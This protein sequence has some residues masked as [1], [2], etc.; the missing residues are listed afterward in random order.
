MAA[1]GSTFGASM[2]PAP[3]PTPFS[4]G[5]PSPFASPP[6]PSAPAG[7]NPPVTIGGRNPRDILLQFYQQHNPNKVG[8]VDRLLAKYQGNEEQLFRNLAKRYNLDPSMFGLPSTPALGSTPAPA[9]P[10]FGSGFGHPSPLGFAGAVPGA[11]GTPF[12]SPSFGS[13]GAAPS[14]SFG[15]TSFGSSTLSS[16]FGHASVMG[17][18]GGG[19]ASPG[20]GGGGT[21]G[22]ASGA[23]SAPAT[24]FG[25]LASSSGFG[26]G[27]GGAPLA[28][29]AAPSSTPSPFSSPAGGA[30]FGSPSPFGAPRR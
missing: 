2:T 5:S 22:S 29:F 23:A 18:G 11:A 9:A 6:A 25:A 1:A 30:S 14:P 20:F 7:G 27:G 15:A 3:A 13:G 16:G 12:S 17:G 10:A 4:Q 8:E 19:M 21:F 28:G 24:S 26:G